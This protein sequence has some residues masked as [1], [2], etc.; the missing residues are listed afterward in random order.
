MGRI[1]HNAFGIIAALVA[2]TAFGDSLGN[3][4]D[5]RL[6]GRLGERLDAMIARHVADRDVDYITAPFMEKTETKGWWQTEFW[7]KWMHA[8]VPYAKLELKNGGLGVRSWSSELGLENG[9]GKELK[10]KIERGVERILASQEPFGYIGNYPDELRC[11]EGWDVWGMKYTMM[12]LLHYYDS[13]Q[14]QRALDAC[15]RLCDYVIAEIGP[16]GKR[17]RAI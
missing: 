4:G 14:S 9:I 7:G 11:G 2:I 8:A 17:G 3:I 13:T 10:C 6:K 5:V 15:C 1:N 12:G 16:N